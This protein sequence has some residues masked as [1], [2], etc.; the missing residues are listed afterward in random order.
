MT[1]EGPRRCR[2]RRPHLPVIALV[3]VTAVATAC[4]TSPGH[5]TGSGSPTSRSAGGTGGASPTTVPSDSPP[6]TASGSRQ[7][8]TYRALKL[9]VPASWKVVHR[10]YSN[11]GTPAHTVTAET[12]TAPIPT[13]HCPMIRG[14]HEGA[15][16]V[17]CAKGRAVGS[18]QS[19]VPTDRRHQ[20]RVEGVTEYRDSD[21][22]AVRGRGWIEVVTIPNNI[23]ASALE[24]SILTSVQPSGGSC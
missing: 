10:G 12:V 4:G 16:A 14:L 2:S 19:L 3:C 22:T 7:E 5:D 9:R 20:A 17:I 13:Y 15:I 6:P 11:C 24:Q 1:I 23:L 18:L 21:A 8:F